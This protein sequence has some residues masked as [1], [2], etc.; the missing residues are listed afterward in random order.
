MKKIIEAGIEKVN[1]T[2]IIFEKIKF[3][4][5]DKITIGSVKY[6][7]KCNVH[8]AGWGRESVMLGASFEKII[9]SH[10]KKG[11]LVVPKKTI[12]DMWNHQSWYP[13]LDTKIS[14]FEVGDDGQPNEKT[15]VANKKIAEYCKSLNKKDILVVILSGG[16][17]DLFCLPKGNIGIQ[18]KIHLLEKLKAAKASRKE[19]NTI[20]KKLSQI[21]GS[22][23]AQLAYPAKVVTIIMSD[24][25]EDNITEIAGAPT[26]YESYTNDSNLILNKYHLHEIISRSIKKI[27]E[28][29]PAP[30]LS[31]MVNEN[32]KFKF[33][34]YHII[35]GISDAME[36]MAKAAF[37]L[38]YVPVKVNPSCLGTVQKM[39]REYAKFA[40]L[41]I[42]AVEGKI[43]KL[44]LH[45]SMID[46][47]ILSLPEDKVKDIFPSKEKWGLGLCLLM[48]GRPL[49]TVADKH[50]RGGP[51]Q[52][53][54][55]YFSIYWYLRVR[56]YPILSNYTVWFLGGNSSGK[57]GNTEVAG[58]YG[59]GDLASGVYNQ[60]KE[61]TDRY[62]KANI[63]LKKLVDEDPEH[64]ETK[65][66][67]QLV[68]N[69]EDEKIKLLAILPD[70]VLRNNNANF[71]FLN[72]NGDE[73][74]LELGDGSGNTS[75]NV[76]DLH[77]IRIVRF[78]CNCDGSCCKHI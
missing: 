61:L 60:F 13:K 25:P 68:E 39:S 53:L 47:P 70:K 38:G 28:E 9:G 19:I 22:G 78:Q 31:K 63:R 40:S 65:E 36:G 51:N 18:E 64:I 17:D 74:L 27:L 26:V 55:L 76:E 45:K 44:E 3:N 34:D 33:V 6:T 30:G 52:E 20:R 11:F 67:L 56:Q 58:A 50:G 14:Y 69:L 16:T 62:N 48:G 46:S 1:A 72:I 10:M 5:K 73:E 12:S 77:I 21:R 29:I 37:R 41:M 4:G 49:V 75:T 43:S 32:G 23:L 15:W 59:Y 42:L 24:V 8:M 57:D 54:A 71:F 35:A 66:A 2:K 7:L